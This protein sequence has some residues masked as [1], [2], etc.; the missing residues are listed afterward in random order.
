MVG[1]ESGSFVRRS[2]GKMVLN[3]GLGV[4]LL[5]PATLRRLLLAKA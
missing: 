1:K 4:L 2:T 3:V 5:M